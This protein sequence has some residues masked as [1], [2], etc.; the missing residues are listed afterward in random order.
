MAEA[1]TL[2]LFWDIFSELLRIKILNETVYFYALTICI[3][4]LKPLWPQGQRGFESHPVRNFRKA[5]IEAGCRP[6]RFL[7]RNR[8][9]FM[10]RLAAFFEMALI[11]NDLR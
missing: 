4:V 1:E 2:A 8:D 6:T 5:K 9:G 7:K 3:R 11:K 10:K